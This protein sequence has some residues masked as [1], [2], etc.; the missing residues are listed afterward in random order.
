VPSI[1]FALSTEDRPVP[2]VDAALCAG[3]FVMHAT[4]VRN[5]ILE[6]R[7]A[8]GNHGVVVLA[9]HEWVNTGGFQSLTV[10]ASEADI[11]ALGSIREK[12]RTTRETTD[13]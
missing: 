6:T 5:W 4:P 11:N 1:T 12:P 7:T 13:G 2:G 10:P 8:A 3:L 9:D